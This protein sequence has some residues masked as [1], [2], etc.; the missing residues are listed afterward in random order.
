[1]ISR[2]LAVVTVLLLSGCARQPGSFRV[3]VPD[4]GPMLFAP[5]ARAAVPFTDLLGREYNLNFHDGYVDLSS[6]MALRVQVARGLETDESRYRMAKVY[7][8]LR[9]GMPGLR[10][11]KRWRFYYAVKFTK[12][13]GQPYHPGFV[14]W[15]DTDQQLLQRSA[16]AEQDPEA[17]CRDPRSGCI[18][19]P[20]KVTASP[21]ILIDAQ[22]K[23]RFVLL[24]STVQDLLRSERIP[25]P[26]ATLQILRRYRNGLSPVAWDKAGDVLRLPL[27]AGDRVSW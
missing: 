11:A 5:G 14:V 9:L 24:S 16:A 27:S 10:A 1:V 22:S 4:A 15:G 26:P 12:A 21:E 17:L 3:S 7:K 2:Y 13:P 25:S 23:P 20:G 8:G 19:F 6:G 18:A